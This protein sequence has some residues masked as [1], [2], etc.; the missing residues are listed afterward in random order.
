MKWRNV[1][2][3]IRVLKRDLEST[4]FAV[5]VRVLSAGRGSAMQGFYRRQIELRYCLEPLLGAT[6]N[7]WQD[8]R[9]D[10]ETSD[11]YPN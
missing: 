6:P 9:G 5:Q 10:G 7:T 2:C 3:P 1:K 11:S 4:L 8:Q